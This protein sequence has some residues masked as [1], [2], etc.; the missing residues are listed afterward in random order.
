VHSSSCGALL[1]LSEAI[2]DLCRFSV[3]ANIRLAFAGALAC[4]YQIFGG[5]VSARHIKVSRHRDPAPVGVCQTVPVESSLLHWVGIDELSKEGTFRFRHALVNNGGSLPMFPF[6]R[7]SVN[8]FRTILR[9]RFRAGASAALS[10]YRRRDRPAHAFIYRGLALRAIFPFAAFLDALHGITPI[11]RGQKDKRQHQK[12]HSHLVRRR[13]I[14][15]NL[16][17]A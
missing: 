2:C 3:R 8:F 16:S 14:R 13:P 10:F 12:P 15:R 7:T 9:R 1:R 11:A 6:F 5:G 4:R 17:S